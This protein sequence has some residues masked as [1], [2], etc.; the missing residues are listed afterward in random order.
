MKNLLTKRNSNVNP[1]LLFF[2]IHQELGREF[3]LHGTR[4]GKI[5]WLGKPR[6]HENKKHLRCI[7]A[8]MTALGEGLRLFLAL[9]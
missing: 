6:N 3:V 5:A 7:G 8:Q 2:G 4:A 9:P 1:Q